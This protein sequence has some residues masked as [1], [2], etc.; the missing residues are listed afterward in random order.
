M[1]TLPHNII[2]VIPAGS[3]RAI[4]PKIVEPIS[5]TNNAYSKGYSVEEPSWFR[6]VRQYLASVGPYYVADKTKVVSE[7]EIIDLEYPS[8]SCRLRF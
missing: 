2:D 7:Y 4:H 5:L 8:S 6:V 1:S 3:V